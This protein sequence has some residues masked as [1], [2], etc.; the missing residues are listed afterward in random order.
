MER[1]KEVIP[2][3][4]TIPYSTNQR[5]DVHRSREKDAIPFRGFDEQERA[6]KGKITTGAWIVR[7]MADFDGGAPAESRVLTAAERNAGPREYEES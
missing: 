3:R 2:F 4:A 5:V 6:R 1:R 7:G